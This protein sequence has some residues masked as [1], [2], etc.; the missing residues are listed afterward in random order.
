M[1][2]YKVLLFVLLGALFALTAAFSVSASCYGYYP[3]GSY[4][5]QY[6]P[7][8]SWDRP[9]WNFL[10]LFHSSYSGGWGGGNYG[11]YGGYGSWGGNYGGWGGYGGYGGWGGGNYGGHGG[12]GG[13]GWR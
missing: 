9:A 8:I 10:S 12:Y 7:A 5:Y 2:T 1:K 13:Y 6:R 3:C 11:G 4:F